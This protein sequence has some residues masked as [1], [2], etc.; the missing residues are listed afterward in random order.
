MYFSETELAQFEGSIEILRV[1][2]TKKIVVVRSSMKSVQIKNCLLLLRSLKNRLINLLNMK[3][4]FWAVLML[5][6]SVSFFSCSDVQDDET[7]E[8]KI[9]K[10]YEE[11][12]NEIR[13]SIRKNPEW[14]AN[15]EK[16]AKEQ[17][18]SV[19]S[20]ILLDA[21]WLVDDQDGKHLDPSVLNKT[22]ADT[23]NVQ[24]R[25]R[26]MESKIRKDA[27]WMEEINRK[28]KERNITADSMIKADAIWMVDEEDGKH[29][30]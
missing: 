19:D 30:Q 26:D 5:M 11:R 13:E 8:V 24:Q 1:I 18:I 15:I 10:T 4:H 9:E 12:V 6:V 14:L 7:D 20:M 16:K 28:A 2:L 25:I 21:R 27:K 22:T 3:K 29:K 17:N 23:T